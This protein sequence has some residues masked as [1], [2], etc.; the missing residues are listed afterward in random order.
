MA[1]ILT[2]SQKTFIDIYDS[3]NLTIN[4]DMVVVTCDSGN[5]TISNETYQ[6]KYS[7]SVGGY[8]ISSSCIASEVPEGFS[9]DT[10]KNG[11][12]SVFIPAGTSF[13]DND[14]LPIKVTITT[15]D[16]SK[17]SFERYITFIKIKN[18]N[19]TVTFQIFSPVGDVFRENIDQIELKTMAY[20]GAIE[21]VGSSY[22]W[23]Y[24]N[25]DQGK[26][27]SMKGMEENVRLVSSLSSIIIAKGQEYSAST[28]KCE[29][30][31]NGAK[32]TDYYS[33]KS[34][35][36]VYELAIKFFNGSNIFGAADSY[37][38]AYAEL[39]KDNKVEDSLTAKHFY[40]G[41]NTVS[42]DIINTDLKGEHSDGDYMYFVCTDKNANYSV[43]LGIYSVANSAWLRIEQDRGKYTYV[44]NLYENIN[45]NI[46][47]IP[48]ESVTRSKEINFS[49]YK[50]ITDTSGNLIYD[51]DTLV[52]RASEIVIDLNDP[53]I[54]K[55]APEGVS[56]GQL[57]LDTSSVPYIL[58]I[59][60]QTANG[61]E[62]VY[63]SQQNGKTVYTSRPSK[64]SAGD[65]WI[66][67]D[68]ETCNGFGSGSMLKANVGS[69]AFNASHWVDAMT[70]TTEMKNNIKQYFSFDSDSGLRIGQKDEKFYVNISSTEMGFYDNSDASNP[71]QKVVSIGKNSATIKNAVV[72]DSAK[73]NCNTSFS[74]QVNMLK[75]GTE[76][77]F[78]W[79][80]EENG[81]LSL[82]VIS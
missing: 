18:E 76:T 1:K 43:V 75:Y 56:Y 34:S 20:I 42:G 11:V 7:V 72:E 81:S 5:R 29:M 30:T 64:Y 68:N 79:K 66:L 12:I 82:V 15:E 73:F 59:Y 54:S 13:G 31:Y 23:S 74:R 33:L 70:D 52:S 28:F 21:I 47:I 40:T 35:D 50:K 80:V 77:G 60:T 55:S 44:N 49:V 78:S 36:T 67:A 17:I 48:K 32:Y 25:L 71:N 65:L 9:V 61:G 53:I 63:F 62:W 10:S 24:Y 58:K 38:I 57:W 16:R 37:L 14:T 8:N 19:A 3:Y 27:I 41:V 39:Y 6:F 26:W 51:D 69:N 45:S 2:T 46:I 4:P 22:E